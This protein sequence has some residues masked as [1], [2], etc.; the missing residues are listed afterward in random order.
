[1]VFPDEWGPTITSGLHTELSQHPG[2]PRRKPDVP[3]A[4]KLPFWAEYGDA[5]LGQERKPPNLGAQ[6]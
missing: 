5:V 1:M 4:P 6:D 2:N 3:I